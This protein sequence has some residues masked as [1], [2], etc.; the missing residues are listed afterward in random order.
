MVA[1]EV[2]TNARVDYAHIARETVKRIGYD[3]PDKGFDYKTCGVM[4]T[5]GKQSPDISQGVTAEGLAQSK[6]QGAGD[7]GIMFGYAVNEIRAAH[8]AHDRPRRT[9]SR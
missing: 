2:T 4:V 1:G 7:Q 3:D 9:S 8:A 5:L 6:E